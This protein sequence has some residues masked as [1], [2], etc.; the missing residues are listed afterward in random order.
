MISVATAAALLFLCN[1]AIVVAW[2]I[3]AAFAIASAAL[4]AI[5]LVYASALAVLCIILPCLCTTLVDSVFGLPRVRRHVS[6]AWRRYGDVCVRLL[7]CATYVCF[8]T[9]LRNHVPTAVAAVLAYTVVRFLSA[10][11]CRAHGPHCRRDTIV[12]IVAMT[13]AFAPPAFVACSSCVLKLSPKICLWWPP[14]KVRAPPVAGKESPLQK[15][16]HKGAQGALALAR[17]R[18]RQRSAQPADHSDEAGASLVAKRRR[19]QQKRREFLR[20]RWRHRLRAAF[21]R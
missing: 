16:P 9:V 10:T 20:Y 3:Y 5:F 8:L 21:A 4:A 6:R 1:P 17:W 19:T 2:P 13:A 7:C 11:T 14:K 12:A 15:V 18:E